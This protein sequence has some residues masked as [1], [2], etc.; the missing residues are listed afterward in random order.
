MKRSLINSD[1]FSKYF[2][3][4]N[5]MVKVNINDNV[6]IH[7]LEQ[8]IYYCSNRQET[9]WYK[10][11]DIYSYN[12]LLCTIDNNAKVLF[13]DIY[14]KSYSNTTAKQTSKLVSRALRSGYKVLYL[15]LHLS[16][17]KTIMFYWEEVE[18]YIAKYI[19][20]YKAKEQYK[21]LIKRTLEEAEYYA[22]YVK[23]DKNSEEYKYKNKL[24]EELF[25]H[26]IL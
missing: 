11:K 18:K 20:A 10:N 26:C 6:V 25:K 9:F 22:D 14:I 4:D 15:P 19:R 1:R 24:T 8:Q 21:F 23:F 2:L 17:K 5:N 16:P 3:K 13:I 12:S 7:Y